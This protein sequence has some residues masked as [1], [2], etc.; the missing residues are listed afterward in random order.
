M[1]V[2]GAIAAAIA[3]V[4]P[5][6]CLAQTIPPSLSG[7]HIG[8]S[9]GAAFPA[10]DVDTSN[11]ISP[12]FPQSSSGDDAGAV[13]GV[14]IGATYDFGGLVLGVEGDFSGIDLEEAVSAKN[15][16]NIESDWFATARGKAGVR[17]ENFVPYATGGAAFLQQEIQHVGGARSDEVLV[18]Y[19]VGGGLEYHL[20]EDYVISAEYLF[21]DF[22]S[23]SLT[24]PVIG[25]STETIRSDPQLHMFRI[26]VSAKF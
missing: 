12:T 7:F 2:S 21:A 16:Y 10:G 18:G 25:T 15:S 23:H 13:G 22:E 4:V 26:G 17:V 3:A 24:A 5:S 14:E 19:T 8:L 6:V 1:R 11:T 9:F 20:N